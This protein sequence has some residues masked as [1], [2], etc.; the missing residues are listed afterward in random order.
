[1]WASAGKYSAPDGEDKQVALLKC[2]EWRSEMGRETNLV[3][4]LNANIH[5]S[6][7]ARVRC[8]V[9]VWFQV[10]R[11]VFDLHVTAPMPRVNVQWE[12]VRL[13]LNLENLKHFIAVVI[14]DLDGDLRG[15]FAIPDRTREWP[16]F[17]SVQTVPGRLVYLCS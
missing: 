5:G 2:C 1:V 15:V 16:A 9:D 8:D 12:I 4:L 11:E 17:C 3:P 14:D 7:V 10:E 13:G 6:C